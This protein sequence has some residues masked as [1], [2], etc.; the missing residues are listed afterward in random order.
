MSEQKEQNFSSTSEETAPQT[1]QSKA[2]RILITYGPAPKAS[3][4]ALLEA[5]KVEEQRKKRKSR[6]KKIIVIERLKESASFESTLC[7]EH[8]RDD[9]KGK[10]LVQGKLSPGCKKEVFIAKKREDPDGVSEDKGF[11][12]YVCFTNNC[13]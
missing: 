9:L 8:S 11:V 10:I 2:K 5:Q 13:W 4:N 6:S 7:E 3:L 1:P 12:N